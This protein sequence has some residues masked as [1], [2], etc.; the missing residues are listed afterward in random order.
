MIT[1]YT[2]PFL[3]KMFGVSGE[4]QSQT[5]TALQSIVS[6]FVDSMNPISLRRNGIYHDRATLAVLPDARFPL[7]RITAP[8][9]VVHAADD[10]LQPYRHG[11]NTAKRVRGAEFLSYEKGGHMLILQLDPVRT[12]VNAF[13]VP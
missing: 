11:V 5:A 3:L 1:E 12:R 6:G 13:L 8:T 7:E 4:V 9:L 10:G 2:K